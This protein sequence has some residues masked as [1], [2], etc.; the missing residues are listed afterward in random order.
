M[1]PTIEPTDEHHLT[2][3][4]YVSQWSSLE[5]VVDLFVAE[6]VGVDYP[7]IRQVISK[8]SFK[9]KIETGKSILDDTFA[10]H[11]P[12][13]HKRKFEK[14]LEASRKASLRRNK[15]VHG[16]WFIWEDKEIFRV[17]SGLSMQDTF[18]LFPSQLYDQKFAANNK[19]SIARLAQE[20]AR[21]AE[22][23]RLGSGLWNDFAGRNSQRR[24]AQGMQHHVTLPQVIGY[25]S[26]TIA[27]SPPQPHPPEST[28][29]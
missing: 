27:A 17:S 25:Q 24:I 10:L 12:D 14:F 9:D 6:L 16:V 3:G 2:L 29:S 15:I 1:L 13:C 4:K 19:F 20:T 26:H 11:I 21:L 22:I 18:R 8:L 28:R 7:A 5:T 23:A